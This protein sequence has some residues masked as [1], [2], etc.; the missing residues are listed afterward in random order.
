MHEVKRLAR[1]TDFVGQLGGSYL[2]AVPPDPACVAE[3]E[4]FRLADHEECPGLHA[5]KVNEEAS[6]FSRD[7]EYS[8]VF[9]ASATALVFHDTC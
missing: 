2:G 3:A 8:R 6:L 4:V 9:R 5:G 1:P 7:D